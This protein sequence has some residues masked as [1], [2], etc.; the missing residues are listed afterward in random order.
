[1]TLF[2]GGK[3]VF[4]FSDSSFSDEDWGNFI[5]SLS[6]ELEEEKSGAD[7]LSDGFRTGLVNAAMGSAFWKV[8]REIQKWKCWSQQRPL[9]KK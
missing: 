4:L 3:N 5:G 8:F 1:M 7:E 2:H 9:L 6:G